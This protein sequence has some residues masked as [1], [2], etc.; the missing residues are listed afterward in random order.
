MGQSQGERNTRKWRISKDKKKENTTLQGSSS[1]PIILSIGRRTKETSKRSE[2]KRETGDPSPSIH[3]FCLSA[4]LFHLQRLELM[5]TL[6]RM[7]KKEDWK[8]LLHQ[9]VFSKCR[10]LTLVASILSLGTSPDPFCS[11]DQTTEGS[12]S[13]IHTR[14]SLKETNTCPL[15]AFYNPILSL[16]SGSPLTSPHL[17]G[18][19]SSR[20]SSFRPQRTERSSRAQ[21]TETSCSQVRGG[22]SRHVQTTKLK[23]SSKSSKPSIE[24]FSAL[25]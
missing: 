19:T 5:H 22:K 4:S 21:E 3:C 8:C 16:C 2:R 25:K 20:P 24:V 15:N 11:A 1:S 7:N 13:Q 6:V 10:I 23:L 14:K 17:T 18:P 9:W 12:Y